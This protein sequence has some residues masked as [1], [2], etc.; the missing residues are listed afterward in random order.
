MNARTLQL[1]LIFALA[2]SSACGGLRSRPDAVRDAYLDALE[3]DDADAAYDLLSAAAQAEISREAFRTMWKDAKGQR[4][5]QQKELASLDKQ[6]KQP[7]MFATTTH[8][9]DKI[10]HWAEVDGHY[11]IVSGLPGLPD[12]SSPRAALLGFVAAAN[13]DRLESLSAYLAPDLA[14]AL[15][16]EWEARGDAIVE[17]LSLPGSPE[18]SPDRTRAVLRY[19]PGR[20]IVLERADDGWRIVLLE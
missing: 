12:R 9:P 1:S 5:R 20:R 4:N 8:G 17:A 3:K 15:R 10:L 11:R 18:V 2:V 7:V 19:A 14:E 16:E 6:A 13:E